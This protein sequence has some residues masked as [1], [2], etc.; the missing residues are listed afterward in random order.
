MKHFLAAMILSGL[1]LQAALAAEKTQA[2]SQVVLTVEVVNGTV[3]GD[4]VTGDEVIVQVYERGELLRTLEGKVAADGKAVFESVPAGDKIVALARSKHNDM[5][6]TGSPVA[7]KPTEDEHLA[8]VQVFD[9]S[10]DTSGLSVQ[11]HHLI[12]KSASDALA[13]TEYMQ[14]VNPSNMAVSSNRED[15]EG[16]AIVLEIKLPR[17]FKDLKALGYFEEDALVV[18]NEGF[19]DT[20]AVPPGEHQVTFTY[21]LDITSNTV[22]IVKGI[23]LPTSKF[24]VF[25][26]LGPAKLQGLGEP[27]NR[28][29]APNGAQIEYYTRDKLAPGEEIAFKITGFNVNNSGS[30]TWV[31]LAAVF[32]AVMVL[33]A[34]RMR[35]NKG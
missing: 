5:M 30:A 3:N 26:E 10:N 25:A 35:S 17:G 32:G 28:A 31:I 7:L 8:R 29:A 24:V 15:A 4:P 20:M 9:A 2:P 14:L 21:S 27:D 12:I 16:R 13:F 22:D 6:F 19:Y 23:T 34:L 1:F 18:T 33:A 11:T